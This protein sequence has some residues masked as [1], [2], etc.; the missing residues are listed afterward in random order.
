MRSLEMFRKEWIASEGDLSF[1]QKLH[2]L[3][4]VTIQNS[5]T[6]LS[7][8]FYGKRGRSYHY[9]FSITASSIHNIPNWQG[10]YLQQG[11]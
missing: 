6:S 3:K 5:K 4:K 8:L 9:I 10:M 1:F 7:A 11:Y 2:R